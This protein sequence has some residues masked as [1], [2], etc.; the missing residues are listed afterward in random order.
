VNPSPESSGERPPASSGARWVEFWPYAALMVLGLGL[1]W[2]VALGQMPMS[3][4]HTVHLARAEMW[5]D[6]LAEG[7]L[8]SWSWT[9]FAG[10][11][12]GEFYPPLGDLLVMSLRAL[13]FGVL[14]W[15]SAYALSFAF[16]F[17]LQGLALCFVALR[18]GL[19]G[20]FAFIVGALALLDPGYMREG[21][22]LYTVQFGVWPQV[23]STSLMWI[24]IGLCLPSPEEERKGIT[25]TRQ[26]VLLLA[27]AWA[28]AILAHPAALPS[29]TLFCPL[30]LALV[31][32]GGTR[33]RDA[34][35]LM[36]ALAVA[37]SLV[38]W[39]LLPMLENRAWMASY[40]WLYA[41]TRVM[42][43]WAGQG[44]WTHNM[45]S[46]VGWGAAFGLLMALVRG[47]PSMRVVAC[48]ALGL[49][50]LASSDVFWTFRLDLLSEG[51]THLQYQ[52]FLLTAK[53]AFYLV[54][55]WPLAWLS[56]SPERRLFHVVGWTLGGLLLASAVH[57]ARSE[58]NEVGSVRVE[59]Q[60]GNTR[61]SDED[62]SDA[63]DW[64]NERWR[65]GQ[66]KGEFWRV[67]YRASR[68]EHTLMDVSLWL[69]APLYKSGFTPGDNFV[70]KPESGKTPVLDS[71]RV[72]YVLRVREG[73][74]DLPKQVARFGPIR[75]IERAL[76]DE[77]TGFGPLR[78]KILGPGT[79]S[80]VDGTQ[81]DGEFLLEDAGPETRIQ[82]LVAGHPRWKA[83]LD[84]APID[85]HET[86][87]WGDAPSALQAERRRG[88]LRGGRADGDDGSE[89]IFIT[90]RP[91]NSGKIRMH[92]DASTTRDQLALLL[93][94]SS[95]LLLLSLLTG[96]PAAL[97]E[98]LDR[99]VARLVPLL[100]RRLGWRVQ[101]A[102]LIAVLMLLGWRW[103]SGSD[104]QS[105]TIMVWAPEAQLGSGGKVG[106]LAPT[107]TDMLIRPSFSVKIPGSDSAIIEL[108]G[109]PC[110]TP[111]EGW[112]AL[113]DDQAKQRNNRARYL[114]E[115]LRPE[116]ETSRLVEFRHRPG[117][118]P[119]RI[120]A[121]QCEGSTTLRL[122]LHN[123]AK[124]RQR[125]GL[126]LAAAE[127]EA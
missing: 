32:R 112:I 26:R 94:L 63:I 19:P 54:A 1:L 89:P 25:W 108:S 91:G 43:K 113:D 52:R 51:F 117:R 30:W 10:G 36:L 106:S 40:G 21:G 4:D 28:C 104:A 33:G 11:P 8:R 72:R 71:L 122:R 105:D 87:I 100:E 35:A 16:V 119:F 114:V 31:S 64:L 6:A 124:S 23:L 18:L 107:K 83:E 69:E 126:W 7:S 39:W 37:A 12:V 101:L 57:L 56:H 98:G 17:C 76:V 46:L 9:W 61:V 75:I 67:N 84:G 20:F 82:F 97:S 102:G 41:P 78:A 79:L 65:E 15:E 59:R 34:G 55:L 24:G 123:R 93:S 22:W 48:F 70:H 120:E 2:P 47:G 58:D 74:R 50:L 85:W 77:S 90:L 42:A 110:A 45:P 3:A 121:A 73:E 115:E 125:F 80:W 118:Q 38:A 14:D 81:L 95:L 29:I 109:L 27:T 88:D 68:N 13:S 103:K 99:R 53:P 116:N 92:Y 5:S 86:P 111:I 60:S 127:D 44:Q 66:A 62:L 49:W 96:R